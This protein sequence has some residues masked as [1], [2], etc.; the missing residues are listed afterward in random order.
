MREFSIIAMLLFSF[1]TV[2]MEPN[3][4]RATEGPAAVDVRSINELD[5]RRAIFDQVKDLAERRDFQGLNALENLYRITRART[6]SGTWKLFY[7]YYGIASIPYYEAKPG[8]CLRAERS[9][10][11][12]WAKVDPKQPGPYI[13]EA[14]ELNGYASCMRGSKTGSETPPEAMAAFLKY[15]KLAI[16]L[17]E[18]H[19]AAASI[20]PEFYAQLISAYVALGVSPVEMRKTLDEAIDHEAYY[21]S[22]YFEVMTYYLPRWY[23]QS[24]D[25]DRLG[26]LIVAHTK[27]D[28]T[29]AYARLFWNYA[30][31]TC[32][33]EE[34]A[35]MDWP[36]V[37]Q[38]MWDILR[39]Y[40]S[41]WNAANFA[42][43]SCKI[44]DL[45]AGAQFLDALSSKEG[46]WNTGAEFMKCRQD[47][48][49]RPH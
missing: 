49:N 27:D 46:E 30:D 35:E 44:G 23:G 47:I 26:R 34:L 24:G 20:D 13:A 43:L 7:F 3:V 11:V 38:S 22:T 10:Y 9:F 41:D 42:R 16:D 12:D 15:S 8:E 31:Q 19:R 40:P 37:K 2:F 1:A 32:T 33:C 17:L 28:G 36:T 39:Q 29:G 5:V 18:A 45:D 14:E 25:I 48:D 4:A 21:Y 6:P